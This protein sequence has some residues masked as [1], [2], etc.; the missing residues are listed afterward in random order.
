MPRWPADLLAKVGLRDLTKLQTQW[1]QLF[2]VIFGSQ[3]ICFSFMIVRSCLKVCVGG[4][5][6]TGG[7]SLLFYYRKR[8]TKDSN[9]S[10][11]KLEKA[12][13]RFLFSCNPH[14]LFL[15]SKRF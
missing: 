8:K 5:T 4:L 10:A 2:M 9:I 14:A 7:S 15:L 6:E 12:T 1:I 11:Y 13:L 3:K